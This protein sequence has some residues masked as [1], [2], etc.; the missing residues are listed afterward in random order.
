ML[1]QA[2]LY[3][4]N[5]VQS[6]AFVNSGE[7]S[8]RWYNFYPCAPTLRA[9]MQ[10]VTDRRTDRIHDVVNSQSDCVAERSA[11]KYHFKML[12][13]T[14]VLNIFCRYTVHGIQTHVALVFSY[15]ASLLI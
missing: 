14:L 15:V 13:V 6:Q 5:A 3:E 10:S 11:K 7:L 4:Q 1:V 8:N 12:N 2:L 9:T